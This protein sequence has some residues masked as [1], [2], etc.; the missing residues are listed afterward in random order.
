[1]SYGNCKVTKPYDENH[2]HINYMNLALQKQEKVI[3]RTNGSHSGRDLYDEATQIAFLAQ[4]PAFIDDSI[5]MMIYDYSI[6]FSGQVGPGLDK[7]SPVDGD[8]QSVKI[9]KE[10][11]DR[12]MKG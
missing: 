12:I 8:P 10:M 2:R 1:M 9:S 7:P 11:L 6:T 3:L 4:C 5:G